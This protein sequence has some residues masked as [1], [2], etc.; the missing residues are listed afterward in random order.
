M[1]QSHYWPKA[2]ND[3]MASDEADA[4]IIA[5]ALVIASMLNTWIS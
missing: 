4:F 3:F 2:V 5:Y 1:T